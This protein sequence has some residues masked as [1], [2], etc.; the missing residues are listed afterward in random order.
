M[1]FDWSTVYNNVRG[2]LFFIMLTPSPKLHH[3]NERRRLAEEANTTD[4]GK[5]REEALSATKVSTG[6]AVGVRDGDIAILTAA[7][8]IQHLFSGSKPITHGKVNELFTVRVLCGHYENAYRQA[9]SFSLR[10]YSIGRVASVECRKDR[11]LVGVP[12]NQLRAFGGGGGPCHEP[13]TPLH[14]CK[15]PLEPPG[16]E[17]HICAA[18]LDPPPG[19]ECLMVSWPEYMPDTLSI[20][21]IGARRTAA[22]ISRNR[23]EYAVDILEVQMGSVPGQSGAPL[24]N[25]TSGVTGVLHGN[26]GG[27]HS[28]FIRAHEVAT[29]LGRFTF[30]HVA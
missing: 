17:C 18:P 19:D 28:Y 24:V 6:F 25:R 30:D 12:Q 27:D 5:E 16:D 11:M 29:F 1:A 13:H 4:K 20:G 7:H 3:V 8:S 9:G 15:S 26:H 2:S 10:D 14:I 21:R 22:Q 23:V